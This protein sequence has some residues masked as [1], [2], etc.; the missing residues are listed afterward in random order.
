MK[1]T[2][3]VDKQ[4][5]EEKWNKEAGKLVGKVV[6]AFSYLNKKELKKLDWYKKDCLCIEFTDGTVIF[7]SC[8]DEGNEAGFFGSRSK[9]KGLQLHGAVVRMARYANKKETE[10]LGFYHRPVIISFDMDFPN[11]KTILLIAQRDAEGNDAG[12]VFGQDAN[13]KDFT[14]PV[15]RC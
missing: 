3:I 9:H 12:A 15:L 1:K 13:G 11:K 10:T 14:L 5:I 2:Y 4:A 8:D 7:P 6:R